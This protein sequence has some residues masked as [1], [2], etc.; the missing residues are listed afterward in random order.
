[1]I[2]AISNKGFQGKRRAY[3]RK[4]TRGKSLDHPRS[5][6]SNHT[7]KVRLPTY[8][9]GNT[10]GCCS[11]NRL[12]SPSDLAYKKSDGGHKLR[13]TCSERIRAKGVYPPP[14]PGRSRRMG[15]LKIFVKITGETN[16]H[17]RNH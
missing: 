7:S 8:L 2:L 11:C 3:S 15:S 10:G 12:K 4:R 14:T 16:D 17:R 5:L 1:M 9:G 6:Q 13:A